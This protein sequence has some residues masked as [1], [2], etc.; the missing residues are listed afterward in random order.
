M[1]RQAKDE[2]LGLLLSFSKYR[3]AFFMESDLAPGQHS[4]KTAS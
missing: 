3:E 2:G 4:L 1:Q